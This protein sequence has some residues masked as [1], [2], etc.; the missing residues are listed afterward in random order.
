MSPGITYKIKKMSTES[1]LQRSIKTGFLLLK[2]VL[3]GLIIAA[4]LFFTGLYYLFQWEREISAH[5]GQSVVIGKDS[6]VIVD[7]SLLNETFTLSTGKKV[8]IYILKNK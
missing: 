3:V 5:V 2:L 7:Y 1:K 8:S 4:V 6:A